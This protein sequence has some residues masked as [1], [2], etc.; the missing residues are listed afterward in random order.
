MLLFA[1]DMNFVE[2]DWDAE[3]TTSSTGGGREEAKQQAEG[4]RGKGKTA[5]PSSV[6]A[7]EN[8]LEED[9]DDA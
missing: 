3:D 6:R 5:Y 1:V 8:W 7:D 9:F 2:E 4:G